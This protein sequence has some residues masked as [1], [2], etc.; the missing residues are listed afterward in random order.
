MNERSM[1]WDSLIIWQ[2]YLLPAV[3]LSQEGFLDEAIA[4]IDDGLD[5]V[6]HDKDLMDAQLVIFDHAAGVAVT[7]GRYGPMMA[8]RYSGQ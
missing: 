2:G 5:V 1:L 7:E 8:C 4:L 6:P 3:S